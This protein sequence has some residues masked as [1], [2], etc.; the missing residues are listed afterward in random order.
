MPN[1]CLN[2]QRQRT[3][4]AEVV[5]DHTLLVGARPRTTRGHTGPMALAGKYKV[6]RSITLQDMER[7]IEEGATC[8]G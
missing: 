7:A 5:D 8:C 2:A 3:H 4:P 1:A 6:D